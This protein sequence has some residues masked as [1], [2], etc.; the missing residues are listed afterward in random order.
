MQQ[1]ARP[2][3]G[4]LHR[5]ARAFPSRGFGPALLW[6]AVP[7]SLLLLA[8][9]LLLRPAAN[10]PATATVLPGITL[11]QPAPDFTLPALH[12]PPIHLA[13]LRGRPVLLNFWS[14]TCDPCT[15]EMPALNRAAH[16]LAAGYGGHGPLIVGVDDPLD[17]SAA[18]AAFARR[19]RIGYP[20]LVDTTYAI[21]YTRYHVVGLPTS[22]FVDRSGTVAA[23]HLGP[24]DYAE[25]MRRLRALD[26]PA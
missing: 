15:R 23:V 21:S 1:D 22:V 11:G 6:W 4:P 25:I 16:D 19:Y 14:V 7:A 2:T 20:L 10:R 8:L 18:S 13:A 5:V 17:P 26:R 12:G 3:G 24:L 9:A